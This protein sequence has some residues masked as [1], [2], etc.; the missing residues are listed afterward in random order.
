MI[1]VGSQV[2]PYEIVAELSRGGMATLYLGRRSG[3]AGFR[4]FVAVKVV[5]RELA[6]DPQFVAMFLDEARLSAAIHH[7]NVVHVEALGEIDGQHYLVMEHIDAVT[8]ADILQGLAKIRQPMPVAVAVSIAAQLADGLHAAHEAVDDKGHPLNLVHRDVSPQNVLVTVPGHLKLI[9]F[10]IAKA[11]GRL[12]STEKGALRGKLAYMSPEQLHGLE[13]DRR[14][15]LFALGIILWEMLTLRRLFWSP[16]ELEIMN[17]VRRAEVQ[18]PS[19]LRPEVPRE[20]DEVVLRALA[21]APE[22]R[23]ETAYA[24]RRALVHALPDAMMVEPRTLARLVQGPARARLEHRRRWQRRLQELEDDSKTVNS[25]PPSWMGVDTRPRLF[26]PPAQTLEEVEAELAVAREGDDPGALALSLGRWATAL[27]EGGEPARAREVLVEAQALVEG[28]APGLMTALPAWRA[29]VA[30][31]EGDFATLVD[32]LVE[33]HERFDQVGQAERAVEVTLRLARALRQLGGHEEA[34]GRLVPAI[35]RARQLDLRPLEAELLLEL[36]R[37]EAHLARPQASRTF[38]RLHGLGRQ[39]GRWEWEAE[40]K[41]GQAELA[42]TERRFED[43]RRMAEEVAEEA[44]Q[45]GAPALRARAEVVAAAAC[46]TLGLPE[47]ARRCC[48]RAHAAYE[49][50]G[51]EVDDAE[52]TLFLVY[53]GSLA[54]LG[55][56][57]RAA[58]L[59]AEGQGRLQGRAGCIAD[60]PRRAA[61]LNANPARVALLRA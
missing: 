42:A 33:A 32:S 58:E 49:V 60:G 15:D 13:V 53:A 38:E 4:R 14:T 46:V 51:R 23:P 55:H 16:N 52:A 10:G 48:E 39:L 36:A 61:F 7:P 2:G 20:V 17:K 31:A 12:Q 41:L 6:E 26:E 47:E 35:T 24:M 27:A 29:Q 57:R 40:A 34:E 54:A 18:A 37:C 44:A 3:P 59:V 22:D 21:K 19:A 1:D 8:V 11:R 9:D 25:G 43:T 45:Q 30:A 56:R 28:R 5:H 50:A